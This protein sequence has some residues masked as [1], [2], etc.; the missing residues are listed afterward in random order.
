MRS[1]YFSNDIQEFLLLLAKY[2]VKYII[3]GGEAVIYYGFAR[4]T[5]DIDFFYE[6]SEENIGNLFHAL[7][8]FWE[9][10]VPGI[11][12]QNELAKPGIIIQFGIPPNRI[13]L[14]NHIDN[15]EFRNAWKNR[16]VEQIKVKNK[17]V[18]VYFIG[19]EELI[20]NKETVKRH[21]DMEDLKYL[22]NLRDRKD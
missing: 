11:K 15:V 7:M 6:N 10:D 4:L 14:V 12:T 19:L 22:K 20:K 17:L 16:T 18:P 21:K 5:G 1:D 2:S 3:V 13:D 8:D 9:G